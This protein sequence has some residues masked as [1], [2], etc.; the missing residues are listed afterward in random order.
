MT[1]LAPMSELDN[2]LAGGAAALQGAQRVRHLV[3]AKACADVRGSGTEGER[4]PNG[5]G[6]ALGIGTR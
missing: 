2:D 1:G 3:E 4:G 5:V 6:Q